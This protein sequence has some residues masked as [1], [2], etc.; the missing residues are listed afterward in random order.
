MYR[1][2]RKRGGA[3]LILL[4]G[5]L[6]CAQAAPAYTGWTGSVTGGGKNSNNSDADWDAS[7]AITYTSYGTSGMTVVYEWTEVKGYFAPAEN[8]I[9]A[10][11][12]HRAVIYKTPT[13]SVIWESCPQTN[14]HTRALDPNNSSANE[15]LYNT[16][17]TNGTE[18]S[19]QNSV[20]YKVQTKLRNGNIVAT[21]H[22]LLKDA[23]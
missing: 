7:G 6:L 12:P 3:G 15:E 18:Q 16:G 10:S 11:V 23:G 13:D 8:Y 17:S 4:L 22:T 20:V 5:L 14:F 9:N 2:S 21:S 19:M 1:S